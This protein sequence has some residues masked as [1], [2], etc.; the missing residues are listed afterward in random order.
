MQAIKNL[1]I[2]LD[3]G[4]ELF[5]LKE[6]AN[7]EIKK[8]SSYLSK[9]KEGS[10]KVIAGGIKHVYFHNQVNRLKI[11]LQLALRGKHVGFVNFWTG[12]IFCL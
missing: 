2:Y 12:A 10:I 11:P 6:I 9:D 7:I 4:W 3:N 5:K 1:H 8:R